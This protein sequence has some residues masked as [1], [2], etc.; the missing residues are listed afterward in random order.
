M[1]KTEGMIPPMMPGQYPG[2]RYPGPFPGMEYPHHFYQQ[3]QQQQSG[4]PTSATTS[5]Q[6]SGATS[7]VAVSDEG[8]SVYPQPPPE[9]EGEGQS[10]STVPQQQLPQVPPPPPPQMPQPFQLPGPYMQ[11]GY[12]GPMPPQHF[13]QQFMHPHM[14]AQFP[15]PMYPIQPG[16]QMRGPPYYP[17]HN[18]SVPYQQYGEFDDPM[19]YGGRGGRGVRG[20]RGRGRTIRGGRGRGGR[21]YN[22]QYSSGGS[23][24]DSGRQTPQ[25]Q[26]Q[27][28]QPDG[29]APS[30]ETDTSPATET[31]DESAAAAPVPAEELPNEQ[32]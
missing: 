32:K 25:D 22:Q 1:N 20:G 27:S 16:M 17:G 24:P 26:S 11:Q 12:Y 7:P 3:A 10:P 13:G 9:S 28:F 29:F 15:R 5:S 21:Q 4:P 14:A 6:T 2:L 18:G 23:Q 8:S 19:N 31:A 30:S